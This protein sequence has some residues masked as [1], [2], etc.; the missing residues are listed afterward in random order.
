MTLDITMP[1]YGSPAHFVLAVESVLAQT[2]PDWRLTVVDDQYPD[3][4]PGRWVQS[5]GDERIVYI[6]NERNLGVSGNFQRCVDLMTEEYGVIMGCDDLL[7]PGYVARIR[8]LTAQFPEAAYVQPGVDIIGAHGEVSY[9]LVDRVKRICRVR[10]THPALYSGEKT[11]AS[12]MRG[13]WTYFPSLCWRSATLKEVGFRPEYGV[14]L[15]LAMQ[16]DILAMG[17]SVLVDDEVVF[18]YRRHEASVS[19]GGA[20]DG[21]RFVEERDYFREL[22]LRFIRTG[23]SRAARSASR[24]ATSRLNAA[25]Q[26]PAALRARDAAGVRILV[27]HIIGS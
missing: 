3:P 13:N 5:L 17:G 7:K 4:E 21:S 11:V 15:D 14:V 23:W 9:P 8:T 27:T 6:R 10:G 19:S 2:D 22:R 26:L 25:S 12:L 18:S 20:L 1:F 24:H 16:V